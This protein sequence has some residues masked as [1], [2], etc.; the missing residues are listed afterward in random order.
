MRTTKD[1]RKYM[2]DP[3]ANEIRYFRRQVRELVGARYPGLTRLEPILTRGLPVA[4]RVLFRM[5][6][7]KSSPAPETIDPATG[8]YPLQWFT[9]SPDI[10]KM[11]RAVLDALTEANV[12][13]DDKQAC[14]LQAQAIRHPKV[15]AVIEWRSLA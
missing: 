1:G 10:D 12:W 7:L 5:P 2:A 14:W 6:L 9:V 13:D 15:G 4:V 11:A 8:A 3:K